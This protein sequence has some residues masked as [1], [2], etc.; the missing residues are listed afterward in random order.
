MEFTSK[1]ILVKEV[2]VGP[3][4]KMHYLSLKSRYD[5]NTKEE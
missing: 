2:N 5:T 4:G 3:G 1:I